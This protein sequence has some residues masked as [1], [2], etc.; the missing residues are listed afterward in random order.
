MLPI[1]RNCL[2]SSNEIVKYAKI[3]VSV[4][5]KGKMMGSGRIVECYKMFLFY[6]FEVQ[7]SIE[8]RRLLTVLLKICGTLFIIVAHA[9]RAII[10]HTCS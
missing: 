2:K 1:T 7:I 9:S 8:T 6:T 4:V 10:W 3:H 5:N